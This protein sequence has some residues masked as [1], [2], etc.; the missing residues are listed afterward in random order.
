MPKEFFAV[1]RTTSLHTLKPGEKIHV[2]GVCGVAMAQIAIALTQRGFSVSGSDK[3]FYEPMKSL[4][5]SSAVKLCVGY[6]AENV[7]TDAS[8]VVIG[9]SISYGNPELVVVEEHNLPYTCFPKILQEVAI[10]GRH[11]IVVTGTHGKSTTTAIIASMLLHHEQNPS[12]FVGGVAQGLPQSLAVGTGPFSVVEGDEYDSA[13]FAKVPKF[14]FYTPDTAVVNAIEYDHADIYANVEAI[15]SEF[16]KLVHGLPKT[17]T[18]VCCVDFPRVKKLVESWRSSAQCA[19]VTFGADKDADYRI[20]AR[21]MEGMSQVVTVRTPQGE[22]IPFFIPLIGE[23][24]ARNATAALVVSEIVGLPRV[25]TLEALKV[26]KTVKRR[27]E[28]RVVKDGIALIEDFAHHP[29]AVQQTISA[30][31]DSFPNA[32][33]WAIF[34]PRSNTSR[35][36][37]FQQEYINAFKGA[38]AAIFKDVT[39]RAIDSGVELI[40]VSALSNDVAAAGTPSVCLPDVSAIREY[41]WQ[42]LERKAGAS[43]VSDVIVVMSNGSFDGLNDLLQRDV[44]GG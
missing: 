12:Y 33:L 20:T 7:P 23:Y 30:V 44:E 29:T 19:I 6:A 1:S 36:K 16:A 18:A 26:F 27:Q 2:I 28:L 42:H 32:K 15:E 8:L 17:G 34:E 22:S 25:K 38:D 10:A 37:V 14:S 43:K 35:R 24:N 40:E 41:L 9:N 4:L 11:S 31:R 5:G 3:E 13:F 21:S 39:A